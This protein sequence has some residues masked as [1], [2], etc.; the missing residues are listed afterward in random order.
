MEASSLGSS[1]EKAN[2]TEVFRLGTAAEILTATREEYNY[3][4][5]SA[6]LTQM[7]PVYLGND[8]QYTPGLFT[9]DVKDAKVFT[10]SVQKGAKW[11]DGEEVTAEDFLFTLN[12]ADKKESKNY[13]HDV[14]TQKNGK[15]TVT[16]RKYESA[17]VSKDKKTFTLTLASPDVRELSNIATIR[18]LPKHIYEKYEDAKEAVIPEKESRVGC[19]AYS[20]VSFSS[21]ANK[22]VFAA[23]DDFF[24]GTPKA[25]RVEVELFENE[26][27]AVRSLS[28]GEIDGIYKY[29]KGLEATA[30][31]SLKSNDNVSIISY[32]TTSCPGV[33]TFN[34][35]SAAFSDLSI[36]EAVSYALDYSAF[37]KAFGSEFSVTP[38]RSFVPS[39]TV[40]YV[41][42][43][44][45]RKNLD[46]VNEILVSKG[47]AKD[48]E[49]FYEKEGR[50][51]SFPLTYNSGK[52]NFV[53]MAGLV[54]TELEEA[55]IE[56]T[57]DG[58]ETSAYNAK[59]SHK[60]YQEALSSNPSAEFMTAALYG[61]TAAGMSML[62]GLG[63]IYVDNAH[64]VQGGAQV[65]DAEFITARDGIRNAGTVEAYAS[66][67]KAMQEFY[68]AKL[69]VISL[70][71]DSLLTAT[72]KKFSSFHIDANW[73][74]YNY[75]TW[76]S[77]SF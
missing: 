65:D 64:P 31:A 73:G 11:D 43:P 46:K 24:M 53:R 28:E 30:V 63:N 51:L 54:K 48:S 3:D 44:E 72:N 74:I 70:Y 39:S 13:L 50:R 40:G 76:T 45:L 1:S 68:A 27:A 10:Y 67:A 62:G 19:G 22:I 61:Y 21:S 14:T 9:F 66:S 47:Y 56:V 26:T 57:L 58:E 17:I 77:L 55:G 41:K 52:A 5:L 71:N 12:Y 29:S 33:L 69:P 23:R 34:T 2:Q 6:S 36:R 35:K 15:T 18:I 8:G 60:F 25:K 42:T 7:S 59:V 49:G 16:A 32:A 75:A 20:F 4:I 37:A 38:E